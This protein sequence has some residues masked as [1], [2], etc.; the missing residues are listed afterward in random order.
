M[1]TIGM[2][3]DLRVAPFAETTFAAQYGACLDMAAWADGIG[4]QSISVS[5]H[6]GDPAGFTPAPITLAAAI[7]GRTR[8]V[9][10]SVSAALV[11]LH[12]PVRLAEQLAT[13]DCLA[14]GRLSVIVGAGYRVAEFEMAGV[15][16]RDRGRLVEEF[17]EV[18]RAAWTGEPFEWRGR[19]LL[20]TPP[21]ATPGGPRLL[22]GGKTEVAARRAARLRCPFS[23]ASGDPALA[24]AY[25]DECERVGFLSGSVEGLGD[26]PARPGFVM[27]SK[28]PDALWERIAP[29]AMYDAE[30]YASWQADGVK[31]DWAI[32]NLQDPE[33]LRTTNR[34]VVVTPEE[35]VALV[36]RDEGLTFHPL[37]CGIPPELAWQSLHLF[38]SEV[39][40]HLSLD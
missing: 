24:K 1:V 18:C 32:P 35:C 36:E 37:M 25:R 12:D 13:V 9:P 17:V 15:A 38:E 22:V 6:H 40:P 4:V 16:R 31:S 33:E 21:P 3:F 26:R 30:T 11:P 2:R 23:P 7:L 39:L 10:V 8:R 27:L 28:D 14:P 5:E 34:Y 19:T 20:V 29:L